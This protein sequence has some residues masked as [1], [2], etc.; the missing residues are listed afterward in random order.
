MRWKGIERSRNPYYR[1]AEKAFNKAL[2]KQL[3]PIIKHIQSN[4]NIDVEILKQLVLSEPID[5]VFEEVYSR[6]GV[7]FAQKQYNQFVTGQDLKN[8]FEVFMKDFVNRYSSGKVTSITNITKKDAQRVI[9][10]ILS[11]N[12]NEPV[13]DISRKLV[14]GLK[15]E[16]GELAKYRARVIARTEVATASN[17]GQHIGAE[18]AAN[19]TG[20]SMQ[21]VWLATMD[22]RVRDTHYQMNGT[23]LEMNELFTV[24]G[25]K[26]NTPGD[27]SASAENVI[28]CRC[29]LQYFIPKAR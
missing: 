10:R 11:E 15:K 29:A 24:N 19:E 9:N 27:P 28:N 6:T 2:L 14:S 20:V 7:D 21:K 25:D 4:S 26:M 3:E 1:Q 12:M 16:G 22:S 18:S 17:I 23:V 13:G 8:R 5:K